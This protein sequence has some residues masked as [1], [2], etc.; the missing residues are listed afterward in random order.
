MPS[1]VLAGPHTPREELLP[2]ACSSPG[3]G[4][5]TQAR[6]HLQRPAARAQAECISL[7]L[8]QSQSHCSSTS[9]CS[10]PQSAVVDKKQ[11]LRACHEATNCVLWR[12]V[13]ALLYLRQ[14]PHNSDSSAQSGYTAVP[15][16]CVSAWLAFAAAASTRRPMQ[17][18]TALT[19]WGFAPLR[20]RIAAAGCEQRWIAHA[21]AGGHCSATF[22]QDGKSSR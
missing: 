9:C 5:R 3:S 2:Q 6:R 11:G 12:R 20:T 7:A 1:N 8:R 19:C 4:A 13:D 21:M 17:N 10:H 15:A 14:S 18:R 22:D 16:A